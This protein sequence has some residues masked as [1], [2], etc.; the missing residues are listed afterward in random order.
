MK[1]NNIISLIA[2]SLIT[3]IVVILILTSVISLGIACWIFVAFNGI[4]IVIG[5][6]RQKKEK[7]KHNV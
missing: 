2:K 3:I 7:N 4:E 5:L 6:I 1:I